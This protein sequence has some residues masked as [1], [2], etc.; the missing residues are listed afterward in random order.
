MS[1]YLEFRLVDAF[2]DGPYAGNPAGVV[3]GADPLDE[4]QMQAIAREVNASETVFIL[5]ANDL[6]RPT[7]LRWFTPRVEAVGD[8]TRSFAMLFSPP[9]CF[10]LPRTPITAKT[11]RNLS[12]S[13]DWRSRRIQ[14]CTTPGS[15]SSSRASSL[16]SGGMQIPNWVKLRKGSYG[17][18]SI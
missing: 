10:A 4:G 1:D 12:R 13:R 5:R 9:R 16:T 2:A 14:S 18:S 3:L 17:G 8:W 6:H 11:M 7:Q 15:T